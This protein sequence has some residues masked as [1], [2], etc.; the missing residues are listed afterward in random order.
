[1]LLSFCGLNVLAGTIYALGDLSGS[2]AV[3]M[4]ARCLFGI[5]GGP[6]VVST[7]IA[8]STPPKARSLA[9]QHVGIGIG[10]GYALGP[11]LGVL[12]EAV[13]N[14][15]GWTH[16]AL[17]SNTAPGWLV[18]F[19]FLVETAL[20][21]VF[22]VEPKSGGPPPGSGG[23]P[24]PLAPEIKTR[25][26]VALT[27]VYFTPINV[28]LW[29]VYT[30]SIA[31]TEWGWSIE[32]AGILLALVNLGVVIGMLPPWTR[33]LADGKGAAVCLGLCALSQAFLF[34]Y[35]LERAPAVVVYVLG[36]LLLLV[37]AGVCKAFVWGFVTK[38]APISH[39]QPI[40][41]AMAAVYMF[42]RGTGSI[43]GSVVKGNAF[44]TTLLCLDAVGLCLVLLT[45]K[46][47]T[48]VAEK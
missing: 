32:L 5:V 46:L 4:I 12:T 13:C 11:L 24:P 43:L 48:P 47:W 44:A 38:I 41:S 27:I 19:L 15:A 8:R 39:R 36:S 1:V 6:S 10:I 23:P 26:A 17:N 30:I 9:M 28:G 33:K 20:I 25:L 14:A 42:G 35:P 40:M 37:A 16:P 29:E 34:A 22:F 21:L 31:L 45:Y 3:V 18:V 2:L 7:Y